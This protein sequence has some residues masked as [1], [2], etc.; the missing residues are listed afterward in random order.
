[1]TCL[2]KYR[3]LLKWPLNC[4]SGPH[5]GTV[6]EAVEP[7]LYPAQK[8]NACIARKTGRKSDGWAGANSAILRKPDL[9]AFS[10]SAHNGPQSGQRR[11]PGS[12]ISTQLP[13]G[14]Q[15]ASKRETRSRSILT[16]PDEENMG[17]SAPW[18]PGLAH[19]AHR[20]SCREL[21]CGGGF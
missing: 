20:P 17:A 8:S 12:G 11:V 19:P 14:P 5:C 10:A 18:T 16:A 13:R 7:P 9:R 3:D 2:E 4:P 1:M 21:P 15:R 6:C